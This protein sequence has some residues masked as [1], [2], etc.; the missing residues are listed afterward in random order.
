MFFVLLKSRISSD[1]LGDG[2]PGDFILNERR[3]LVLLKFSTTTKRKTIQRDKLPFFRYY[4]STSSARKFA[5]NILY[6]TASPKYI[7]KP[8]K[9][10]SQPFNHKKLFPEV[11]CKRNPHKSSVSDT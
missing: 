2:V 4:F 1:F 5:Q 9:N 11:S 6:S 8:N 10:Q 7:P 3:R